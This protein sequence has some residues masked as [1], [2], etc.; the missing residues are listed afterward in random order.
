MFGPSFA[1]PLSYWPA[2][3]DQMGFE[4]TPSKEPAPS[5]R[6][7][8]LRRESPDRAVLLDRRSNYSDSR[9]WQGSNLQP[10]VPD[11]AR[12]FATP[13]TLEFF[14]TSLL[15]CFLASFRHTSTVSSL[16]CILRVR[17]SGRNQRSRLSGFE[18]E[19]FGLTKEVSVSFTIP[20]HVSRNRC[21]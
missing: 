8:L 9:R 20:G 1:L 4:P 14:L 12:A 2:F 10:S 5:P 16:T 7:K 11:V 13:Q 18:P 17:N 6:C 19:P 21:S 3:V 15:R